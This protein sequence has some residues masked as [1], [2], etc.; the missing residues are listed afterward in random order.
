MVDFQVEPAVVRAF[1]VL[2]GQQ[3]D[4][5][6]DAKEYLDKQATIDESSVSNLSV[7]A[8]AQAHHPAVLDVVRSAIG[9][10]VTFFTDSGA[11]L[12][13]TADFYES[14]D[15]EALAKLD[16]AY[17]GAETY[18][19]VNDTDWKGPVGAP[20]EQTDP[21]SALKEPSYDKDDF[22]PTPFGLLSDWNNI[23]SPAVWV[24]EF[25]K[26]TVGL[27]HP[28]RSPGHVRG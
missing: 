21:S 14:K 20:S 15:E 13:D 25:V 24:N 17:E 19:V 6:A 23:F 1:G 28:E 5:A 27:R 4:H 2:I 22:D 26:E 9:R 3:A 16:A 18:D 8:T 11:A 12:G 10:S 7:I